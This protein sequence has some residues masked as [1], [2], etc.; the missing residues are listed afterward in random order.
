M[1]QRQGRNIGR[2]LQRLELGIT[3]VPCSIGAM[4]RRVESM[5]KREYLPRGISLGINILS[6]SAIEYRWMLGERH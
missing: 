3:A 4:K 5:G 2:S 6:Q 1:N